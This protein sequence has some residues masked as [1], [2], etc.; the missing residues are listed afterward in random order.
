MY[1]LNFYPPTSRFRILIQFLE[2][3]HSFSAHISPFY[4]MIYNFK[5]RIGILNADLDFKL[6]LEF[7]I[8]ICV[9]RN[10]DHNSTFQLIVSIG[11][12]ILPI[13]WMEKTPVLS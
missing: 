10:W 4:V 9:D 8:R 12:L 11:I 1:V 5:T 2:S 3:K 7:Q 6:K 13:T